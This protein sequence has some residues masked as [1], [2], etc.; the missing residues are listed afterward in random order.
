[1]EGWRVF[2][3]YIVNTRE[4]LA[5]LAHSYLEYLHW[6]STW[7]VLIWSLHVNRISLFITGMDKL[8][9]ENSESNYRFLISGELTVT[10]TDVT[11]WKRLCSHVPD[12]KNCSERVRDDSEEH[13]WSCV[14]L[15]MCFCTV[16]FSLPTWGTPSR[17]EPINL[18]EDGN[19]CSLAGLY[20]L[21]FK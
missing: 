9:C 20:C 16:F 14:F 15:L 3:L 19:E 8:I 4:V 10:V 21:M 12:D 5:L 7:N 11:W 6:L 17:L 1:M 2:N 18:L 13:C